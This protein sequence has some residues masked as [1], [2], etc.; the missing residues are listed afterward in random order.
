MP[1]LDRFLLTGYDMLCL[2]STNG[3]SWHAVDIEGKFRHMALMDAASGPEGTVLIVG[4][5]PEW[6][7]DSRRVLFTR[8]LRGFEVT[9]FKHRLRSIDRRGNMLDPSKRSRKGGLHRLE[10]VAY[11]NGRFVATG[12]QAAHGNKVYTTS[13]DGRRWSDLY[14]WQ[15]WEIGQVRT[16]VHGDDRFLGLGDFKRISVTQD[17]ENWEFNKDEDRPAWLSA[18]WGNG[19]FVAG[20]LHGLH[21][22][23]SD[24]LKWTN[25]EEGEIGH[26]LNSMI[27][28][29][30]AFIG[31]GT[32]VACFSS[33]GDSW[34]V[35][36]IQPRLRQVAYGNGVFVGYDVAARKLYRSTDALQWEEV[37]LELD[38]PRFT[39]VRYL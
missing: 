14:Y 7:K 29:G 16:L 23:S 19:R 28:T 3:R 24:G 27:W 37:E 32:Q 11:G 15:S 10:A 5:N 8:D 9:S 18:A 13:S 25:L 20:G 39:S 22:V 1:Q 35:E 36:K 4:P 33:N 6:R 38:R 34:K 30:A 17:G 26:H 21:G 2:Q 31:L 12:G